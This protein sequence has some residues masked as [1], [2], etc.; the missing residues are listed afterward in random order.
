MLANMIKKLMP[1]SPVEA[2]R[3]LKKKGNAFFL[4]GKYLEAL[5]CYNDAIE[6]DRIEMYLYSNKAAVLTHLQKFDEA[7]NTVNEGKALYPTI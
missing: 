1:K 6:L 7:L 2:A 5:K 4:E 3:K